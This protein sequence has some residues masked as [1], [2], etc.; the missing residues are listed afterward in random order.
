[1]VDDQV[2][3][4]TYTGHL[5][6]ALV[7]VAER[8]LT[9]TLHVAGGG[10]CS[11]YDLA[12]ATFAATDAEVTLHRTTSADLRRPAPRPAFS[13]LGTERDDTPRLPD[14]RDGTARPPPSLPGD[15]LKLLVCG[16]AGFI[17]SHFAR[18]RAT[19][20]GDEVVVLDKLTYAGRRENLADVG[21][22]D[23]VRHG[24]IEDADA[25]AERPRRRRRD[26]QLRRRDARRPLHRRA[27]RVRPDPRA[28][29]PHAAG[30][31]PR[32]RRPLRAGLHRRGLRLHRRGHLHR[33]V[34]ARPVLAVL[35]DQGRRRP[36][37]AL[38]LPHLR[39]GDA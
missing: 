4:P 31:R 28:R 5:A 16:G 14:W 8:G 11:W 25:V 6:A 21:H 9:G 39:D 30:G 1:M 23:F 29:H 17:G 12:A 24:A 36:A 35:G 33:G 27:R 18:I 15:H 7:E 13:V 2:G 3:C 10:R 38:L 22:A 34:P 19:E 37:G 32:R 20:H 26:R